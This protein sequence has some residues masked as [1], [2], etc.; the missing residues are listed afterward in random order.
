MCDWNR[1]G[2]LNGSE[3]SQGYLERLAL[4]AMS[5]FEPK[6]R[7]LPAECVAFPV[8]SPEATQSPQSVQGTVGPWRRIFSQCFANLQYD[9]HS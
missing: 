5:K 1:V 9:N 6:E 8:V 3:A 2:C 4:R 7:S